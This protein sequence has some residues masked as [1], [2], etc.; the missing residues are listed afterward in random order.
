VHYCSPVH[1]F[2]RNR[3]ENEI[4]L[5]LPGVFSPDS[6][7]PLRKGAMTDPGTFG[8]QGVIARSIKGGGVCGETHTG[9]HI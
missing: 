5:G 6:L 3:R 8:G 9:R 1:A 4:A 2:E 7:L